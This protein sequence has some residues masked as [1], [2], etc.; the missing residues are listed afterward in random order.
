GKHRDGAAPRGGAGPD[1]RALPVGKEKHGRRH[2]DQED[3]EPQPKETLDHPCFREWGGR[4]P[5]GGWGT[6]LVTVPARSPSQLRVI[7]APLSSLKIPEGM[8]SPVAP[9]WA[10][11]SAPR[12]QAM[13][14][15]LLSV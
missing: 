7:R 4:R 2:R 5:R 3:G 13:S 6:G 15:P 9:R 8:R 14:V 11:P 12:R 1:G 10:S